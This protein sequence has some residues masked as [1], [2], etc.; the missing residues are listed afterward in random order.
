MRN[1]SRFPESLHKKASALEA[2]LYL[3][4][5]SRLI[6]F[7]AGRYR[8]LDFEQ[9]DRVASAV[10][11]RY[12]RHALSKALAGES[13]LLDRPEEHRELLY[14]GFATQS[15]IDEVR[16]LK[17]HSW[18]NEPIDMADADGD[19]RVIEIRSHDDPYR[20]VLARSCE[21]QLPRFFELL[22]E[23]RLSRFFELL[24]ML[25][26][27]MG[28]ASLAEKFIFIQRYL[29]ANTSE[30]GDP[31]RAELTHLLG[32]F[33]DRNDG[34]RYVAICKLRKELQHRWNKIAKVV[35][36]T[37]SKVESGSDGRIKSKTQVRARRA[38]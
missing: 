16:R 30:H 10:R 1:Y 20:N 11:T 3:S 23:G 18:R 29:F 25:A 15:V 4:E 33:V 6:P 37:S 19:V 8:W 2:R 21:A 24:R 35:F 27:D 38:A 5:H 22:R 7:L 28:C 31:A 34:A 36:H 26:R 32:W 9:A 14:S 17:A 12:V 13:E